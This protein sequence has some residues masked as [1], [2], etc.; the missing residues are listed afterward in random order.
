MPIVYD[1]SK[2]N[3]SGVYVKC[4]GKN[5]KKTFE[6][7]IKNGKGMQQGLKAMGKISGAA[8]YAVKMGSEFKAQ[9]ERLNEYYGDAAQRGRDYILQLKARD[10]LSLNPLDRANV[11]NFYS[12]AI[13]AGGDATPTAFALEYFQQLDRDV[14][15]H[16]LFS[17]FYF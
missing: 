14:I 15:G 2:A 11:R 7:K 5:C 8:G 10:Y 13:E 12:E 4:K 1:E 6:V 3:C 17:V 16:G 9:M